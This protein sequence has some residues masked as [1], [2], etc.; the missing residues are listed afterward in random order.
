[1]TVNTVVTKDFS[2]VFGAVDIGIH[3]QTQ[4]NRVVEAVEHLTNG[5]PAKACE[6][7][8]FTEIAYE[9]PRNWLRIA[10]SQNLI[11]N[12]GSYKGWAPIQNKGKRWEMHANSRNV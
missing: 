2:L 7:A 4:L 5:R 6:V 9:T 11:R 12:M 10:A 8:R 3:H 1:M